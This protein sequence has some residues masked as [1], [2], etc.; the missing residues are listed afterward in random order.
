MN[1]KVRY[2]VSEIYEGW[3]RGDDNKN[4]RK[5]TK[6]GSSRTETLSEDEIIELLRLKYIMD[7]NWMFH[8]QVDIEIEGVEI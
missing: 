4:V 2:N 1:I 7:N 8:K 3:E 6:T 5:F